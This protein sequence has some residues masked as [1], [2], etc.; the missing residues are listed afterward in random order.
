M[1]GNSKK[2]ICRKVASSSNSIVLPSPESE[3]MRF[4]EIAEALTNLRVYGVVSK[5]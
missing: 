1:R 2:K 4:A 5:A 3:D